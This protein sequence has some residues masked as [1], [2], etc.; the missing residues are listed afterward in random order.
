MK[1]AGFYEKL[2]NNKVRCFLCS[3]RCLIAEGK[4]GICGVRENRG[5]V[6]FSL[7]YGKLISQHIDP[8][9]K[10]PFFHFF[11]GS[12]AYS[13]ATVG[14]N[15][16]CDFCQN[17]EISQ[18]V[19]DR[20]Q[21]L[22]EEVSPR[23]IVETALKCG[24][25][26][27]S[28]TYTEPTIAYEYYKEVMKIAKENGLHNNFVTNG[29]M[30]GEML[31]D[32][33][34]YLEAANVD[35]KSFDNEFY[36]KICGAKLE[37]V[38]ETLKIMKEMNIWLEITTLIIPGL[39]NSEE[40]IK[41][42]AEFIY[43]LGEDIPWHISRFYPHYRMSHLPPTPVSTLRRARE[44]GLETGLKYVYIGNLPGDEGENTY[45][46]NCREPLILREGFFVRKI[47]LVKDR[48]PKCGFKIDIVTE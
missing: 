3:H 1:E 34:G 23:E 44:I 5:G 4:R 2:N 12:T 15:F 16:K 25:Q 41:K 32:T 36:K 37:A 10:K 46:Y 20:N 40:E 28:Y 8:I 14:C 7:V 29:Y 6:L 39:N 22:G 43:S 21:I 30:T 19:R 47:N 11:P 45:C 48:C 9:E 33:Y 35:L 31:K 38:L 24:C 42:C 17:Y 13:I 26:S 27:I 18:I